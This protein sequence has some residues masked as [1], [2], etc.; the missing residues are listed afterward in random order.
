MKTSG[1]F[2]KGDPRCS[3]KGRPKT[4]KEAKQ[5]M[6]LTL[7]KYVEI[8][9]KFLYMTIG[10]LQERSKDKNTI[11]IEM[12]VIRG[13]L[14]SVAGGDLNKA[15]TL[16]SRI[17]GKQTIPVDFKMSHIDVVNFLNGIDLK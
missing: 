1:S 8:V 9:N 15:E 3:R 12:V 6:K 13:L 11:A 17:I 14:S 10:E 2:V 16:L 7:Q 5:L 4:S